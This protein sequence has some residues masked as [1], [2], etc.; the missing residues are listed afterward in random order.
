MAR[1]YVHHEPVSALILGTATVRASDGCPVAVGRML[2]MNDTEGFV[3]FAACASV[4]PPAGAY[5]LELQSGEVLSAKLSGTGARM[6]VVLG[7]PSGTAP[8]PLIDSHYRRLFGRAV[9][10]TVPR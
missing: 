10:Y 8:Q 6:R 5:T 7:V 2:L 4:T 3:D 1:R 9:P